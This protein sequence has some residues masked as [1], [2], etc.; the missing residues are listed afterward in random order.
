MGTNMTDVEIAKAG[1]IAIGFETGS[2]YIL[3]IAFDTLA[4]QQAFEDK[5]RQVAKG[6]HVIV[7]YAFQQLV[8]VE[9]LDG[10]VTMETRKKNQEKP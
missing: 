1:I 6:T 5:V 9:H 10:T 2:N 7:P 4:N 8:Y 3:K